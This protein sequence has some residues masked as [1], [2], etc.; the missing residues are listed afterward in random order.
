[1]AASS[2]SEG[3]GSVVRFGVRQIVVAD[4]R[5]ELTRLD[6]EVQL[7]QR[8]NRIG[9]ARSVGVRDALYLDHRP[10]A[11]LGRLLVAA[12]FV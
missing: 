5:D 10:I 1:M 8:R 6:L 2:G 7:P 3:R 4:D 9:L 12:L 11:A